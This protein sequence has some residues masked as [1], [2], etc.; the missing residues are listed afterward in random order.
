MMEAN[1]RAIPEKI[2]N[3][4]AISIRELRFHLNLALDGVYV[5]ELKNIAHPVL[6]QHRAFSQQVDT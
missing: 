4:V 2:P 6:I 1:N 3:K 5:V